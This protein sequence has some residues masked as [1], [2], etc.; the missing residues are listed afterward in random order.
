[1][2]Y[3]E[4]L[5]DIPVRYERRAD[6]LTVEVGPSPGTVEMVLYGVTAT[7]ASL[8]GQSLTLGEVQSGQ[9]VR[10]DGGGGAKTEFRLVS[11]H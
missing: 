6:S 10:F 8:D 9:F 7:A 3:D 2:I 4:D 5:P 11:E 1:V